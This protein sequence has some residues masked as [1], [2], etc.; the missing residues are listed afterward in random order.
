MSNQ[1]FTLIE[2]VISITILVV[3]SA[4]AVPGVI[5][6]QNYQNEEQF[7][8]QTVNNFRNQQLKSITSDDFT[9][10]SIS[11]TAISFCEGQ[12]N[13]NCKV[14]NAGNDI[15]TN[16]STSLNTKYFIDKFGNT[17]KNSTNLIDTNEIYLVTDNFKITVTKYGG[18]YKSKRN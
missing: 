7:V 5:N 9:N 1:G 3:I 18:I 10:F 13:Q 2:L 8:N 17:Y 6:Y 15:F 11:S 12:A 16:D 4:F 14:F